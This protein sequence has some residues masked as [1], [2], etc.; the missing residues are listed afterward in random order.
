[1]CFSVT[2]SFTASIALITC[3]IAALRCAQ[4]KKLKMIAA[5][6]LLFGLQQFAEGMVWLS[7]SYVSLES[8]RMIA[9]YIFLTFAAVVWPLWIPIATARFE[10]A[11]RYKRYLPSL[12]AGGLCALAFMLYALFYPISV[13][14]KCNVIYYFGSMAA[15]QSIWAKSMDITTSVLYVVATIV[16]FFIARNKMLWFIGALVAIAYVVSY[17]AYRE[18]FASVWCFFAAIISLLVYGFVCLPSHKVQH[19]K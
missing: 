1:M 12:I 15:H 8:I 7:F 9:A 18:A 16:P 6:P 14:A 2:A 13:T 19:S 3:S 11:H 4:E 5:I 10:G 17:V